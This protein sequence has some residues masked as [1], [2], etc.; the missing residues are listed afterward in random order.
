L[1][2]FGAIRPGRKLPEV[3]VVVFAMIIFTAVPALV[4]QRL[5]GEAGRVGWGPFYRCRN[6]MVWAHLMVSLASDGV[7][8][9]VAC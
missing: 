6:A 1:W 3:N 8:R 7:A 4:T 2:I 5:I 9:G